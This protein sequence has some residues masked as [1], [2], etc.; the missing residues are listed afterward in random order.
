[1]RLFLV[2]HVI[3]VGRS[4]ESRKPVGPVVPEIPVPRSSTVTVV[5]AW[6][7]LWPIGPWWR[8][9]TFPSVLRIRPTV[10]HRRPAILRKGW[11]GQAQSDSN[12]EGADHIIHQSSARAVR[13]PKREPMNA[14]R[15]KGMVKSPLYVPLY[16]TLR[17]KSSP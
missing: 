2:E 9:L 14:V 3:T 13:E 4:G 10:P 5:D 12:G 6:P 17:S 7:H 11:S 8:K 16:H 15:S 1:M